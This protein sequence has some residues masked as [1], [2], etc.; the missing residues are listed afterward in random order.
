MTYFGVLLRFIL[1]ALALMAGL[2]W[3]DHKQGRAMPPT[4]RGRSPWQ[5][6]AGLIV[7]AVVWTTPWDNYLVATEV[8][9][10]LPDR[11]VGIF[12][13]WVPLEEYTFFVVQT[14]LSSM[15]VMWLAPRLPA[16]A[17]RIEENVTARWIGSVIVVALWLAALVILLLGWVPGRYLALILIWLLPPVLIQAAFGMEIIAHHGRL[18]ITAITITTAYLWLVDFVAIASGAWVISEIQTTGIKLGGVL[19]IE[20]MTFFL[21]TNV[22]ITFGMVL[23]MAVESQRRAEGLPLL[24]RIAGN[25]RLD[26]A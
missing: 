22:L 9:G 16:P 26:S 21:V 6:M 3:W 18:A 12:F 2:L 14:A 15:V 11:V 4:L 24:G 20:E 23:V 8:W 1:P 19:P 7:V 13:G 25:T 10:Y 17:Q 5:I